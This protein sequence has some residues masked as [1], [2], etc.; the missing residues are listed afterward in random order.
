VKNKKRRN[1]NK[2]NSIKKQQNLNTRTE[3]KKKRE[4]N[5]YKNNRTESE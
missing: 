3:S 2:I 5:V 4:I 1:K